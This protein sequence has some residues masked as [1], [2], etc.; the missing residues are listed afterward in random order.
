MK[1][2]IFASVISAIKPSWNY[3]ICHSQTAKAGGERAIIP[4]ALL[5]ALAAFFI[6]VLFPLAEI[7]AQER[8]TVQSG[9]R[10]IENAKQAAQIRQIQVKD[11]QQDSRLN[12][13]ES[14]ID[15]IAAHA[16][17]TLSQCG[18]GS[19]AGGTGY[20][21][22]W[23]PS[24]SGSW[25]C[26]QETDPTVKTFAKTNLPTCGAGQVLRA[27]GTRLICTTSAGSSGFEV[28]PYVQDFA[29]NTVYTIN[30][31]ASDEVL[32]M[33]NKRLRCIKSQDLNITETDPTVQ[34]FAKAALPECAAG[35]VL[36]T[37]VGGG[38]AVLRC[39]TDTDGGYAELDPSVGTIENSKW[40]IASSGKI[41]CNQNPPV[42]AE[43]DPTVSAFA[44]AT[45]P[46][47]AAGKV[48]TGN[49][50]ALTCADAGAAP[51]GSNTHV[52]YNSNGSLGGNGGF[53]YNS[54]GTLTVRGAASPAIS[55]MSTG[56]R[57]ILGQA[58][59]TTGGIGVQGE[60][61][62]ISGRGVYGTALSATGTTYG[63]YGNSVSTSGLGV[64]GMASSATGTTYG[65]YGM[66]RSTTGRGVYGYAEVYSGA[67]YGVHG[68]SLSTAGTGV[69]GE[70][71]ATSGTTYGVYGKANS[72]DGYGVYSQG[73]AHVQG[74][75]GV[76]G[77]VT[78]A[79]YYQSS[80]RDLKENITPVSNPF[81]LLNAI[82]GKHY[83]WKESRKPAYG[84]IA[85]DVEK[86]MPEAVQTTDSGTKTVEY[87]QLIAPMLE[88]I[89]QLESRLH[90]VEA[91]NGCLRTS[92]NDNGVFRLM[93]IGAQ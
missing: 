58:A 72:P 66:S 91:S 10:G 61:M 51:G 23:N 40:C 79:S 28:D 50:T 25:G 60:A 78:A 53:T 71:F 37:G 82:E 85:Q 45:L 76:A 35:Q 2:Y 59:D 34:P 42:L 20:K 6:F 67:N 52:Q 22:T 64:Y 36:T 77:S 39:V 17:K 93:N 27:D 4:G 13:V 21:I 89:K 69:F 55:G 49:G 8:F 14:D 70:A 48:L 19:G 15:K 46:T 56:G 3:S 68:R 83:T 1:D 90:K 65:V 62:G 32:T 80:D 47:C 81:D 16:W 73:N 5:S 38:V 43:T 57:G 24:G 86:V 7:Q 74:E 30:A 54:A 44:K 63:V 33:T 31:C 88:A 11:D 92:D 26:I 18:I 29:R 9:G 41:H 84:V 12:A 87:S 75:L